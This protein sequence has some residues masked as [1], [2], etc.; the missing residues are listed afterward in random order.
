MKGISVVLESKG[1]VG[2][3][4]RG[5]SSFGGLDSSMGRKYSIE[6]I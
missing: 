1:I 3:R 4:W 5:R 2:V 6:G